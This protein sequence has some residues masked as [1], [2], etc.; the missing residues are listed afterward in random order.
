MRRFSLAA[1]S[2]LLPEARRRIG[3]IAAMTSDLQQ[4]SA[5]IQAGDAPAGSVPEAKALEAR[6]DERMGWFRERGV[7]VKG[8]A[9]ALLDFPATATIDGERRDVLLCWR[10]GEEEIAF[11]HPP[12]TGYLGRTPVAVADEI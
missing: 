10:E 11:F 8:I 5:A 3:Q 1:A 9:P 4:R 12:E 2:E 6:I 7:Q